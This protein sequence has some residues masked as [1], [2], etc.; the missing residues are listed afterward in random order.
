[1]SRKK[2]NI[3]NYYNGM[4][5]NINLASSLFPPPP[6]S[7]ALSLVLLFLSTPNGG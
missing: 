7:I 2:E 3:I 6:C 4:Y 5:K 1:M